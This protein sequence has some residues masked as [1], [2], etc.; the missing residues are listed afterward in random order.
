MFRTPKLGTLLVKAT[1]GNSPRLDRKPYMIRLVFPSDVLTVLRVGLGIPSIVFM[2]L[3]PFD[4]SIVLP[5]HVFLDVF[6][7]R[8]RVKR[9]ATFQFCFKIVLMPD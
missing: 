1:L 2:T 4:C 5:G 3:D 9:L 8:C 7:E 6:L